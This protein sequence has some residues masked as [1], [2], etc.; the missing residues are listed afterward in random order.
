MKKA[1]IF[2]LFNFYFLKVSAQTFSADTASAIPISIKKTTD[3]SL[4]FLQ[5]GV[6]KELFLTADT[7]QKSKN[8]R[9]SD[10]MVSAMAA[11]SVNSSMTAK[12]PLVVYPS[13]NASAL[14][15]A[16]NDNIDLYTGKL[17]ASI[18]IYT[19]KGR[20]ISIPI[21]LSFNASGHKVDDIGSWVGM[22]WS[23]QAGGGISRVMHNLPDEFTGNVNP[24]YFPFPAYGYLYLK[25][26]P[27]YVDL[28]DFTNQTPAKKRQIIDYANWQ[29]QNGYCLDYGGQCPKAYDTH[30]DEFYFNFPGYS[31]KFVFDQDGNINITPKQNLIITKTIQNISGTNTLTNFQVITPDGYKYE[32]GGFD[33]NA[34]EE[35]QLTTLTKTNN[36]S[37]L[38][39]GICS[40]SP[41]YLYDRIPAT[42]LKIDQYGN[43][44]DDINNDYIS[45][46]FYF[47]SSWHLTSVTSP[48]GDQAI[49]EYADNGLLQYEQSRTVQSTFP[50]FQE[51]ECGTNGWFF[52]SPTFYEQ[53]FNGYF[54]PLN[55]TL[56][57]SENWIQLRSKR[58]TKVTSAQ[59]YISFEANTNR[60]DLPND[61]RLDYIRIY[62][63]ANQLLKKSFK[64]DYD[65]YSNTETNATFTWYCNNH[66]RYEG[67]ESTLP[68]ENTYRMFLKSV[69]ELDAIGQ[70]ALAYNFEYDNT[71]LPPRCSTSQ[72]YYGFANLNPT[73]HAFGSVG[74][75]S[76]AGQSM[77]VTTY[78]PLAWN[79]G[80]TQ[81]KGGIKGYN[82]AKMMAGSLKK[83]YYPTGGYKEFLYDVS[84]DGNSWNGLR[85]TSIKE[86]DPFST[87]TIT[88]N[89]TPTTYRASDAPSSKYRIPSYKN[90]DMVYISSDRTLPLVTTQGNVGGYESMEISKTGNGKVKYNFYTS[91]DFPDL[92]NPVFVEDIT[93]ASLANSIYGFP[94]P[95]KN[96]IDWQRGLVKSEEY[97]DNNGNKVRSVDYTYDFSPPLYNS[98]YSLSL[99]PGKI[100]Y[101]NYNG[102]IVNYLVRGIT[103]YYSK[104]FNLLSKTEKNYSGTNSFDQTE[105]YKYNVKNLLV[106]ETKTM[107]SDGEENVS[108]TKYNTDYVANSTNGLMPLISKSISNAVVEKYNYQQLTG[109]TN[110]R[111]KEGL[112]YSYFTD[113]PLVK[114]IHTLQLS[115][116]LTAFV[117]SKTDVNGNFSKDA[118]YV[119]EL[120]FDYDTYGNIRQQSQEGGIVEQYLYD[121]NSTLPIAKATNVDNA[122]D[123]AYTSFE[124][125]GKG[126]WNYSGTKISDLTSPTG[127][128][129]YSLSTGAITKTGLSSTKSYI[130]SYWYKPGTTVNVTG[131]TIGSEINGISR[132]DGWKYAERSITGSIGITISA[133]SGFID[134][135]KLFPA[136]AQMTTYSYLPLT[137]MTTVSESNG[138]TTTYEYDYSQRLKRTYNHNRDIQSEIGYHYIDRTPNWQDTGILR[139]VTDASGNNTGEQ[140]KEQK[141]VNSLSVTYNT[142]RWVSLGITG[143]CPLPCTGKDKKMINGICETGVKVT[144]ECVEKPSGG[145][146][147]FYHY[148][149]SDGST[150]QQYS[151]SRPS[152]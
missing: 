25:G 102:D 145:C 140:Q 96:I 133:A 66:S 40:G 73:L 92:G 124:A 120:N 103:T 137:G 68:T 56:S 94:F 93:G 7:L 125:D 48:T 39:S 21:S 106:N 42:S 81:V 17:S 82:L 89:Y 69:Q 142:T 118:N 74:Y 51:K 110:K 37:Y 119:P 16:N 115:K 35:S 27:E 116:P 46:Y 5:K 143:Q 4:V 53:R 63:G 105:S 80:L 122:N 26:S 131:G 31:G 90:D 78:S 28:A 43:Y 62:G 30:P 71:K 64:L 83:I 2:I 70:N 91:V 98:T 100:A 38:Y 9:Q 1:F 95:A 34:V 41:G 135:L 3:S 65:I 136:Y 18:P 36:Y 77:P 52:T 138:I 14:I 54:Y 147:C 19:L 15:A 8:L 76:N 97:Y 75:T 101:T 139:C 44:V 144:D 128:Y 32:F 132:T 130:L 107:R 113:K 129:Y 22:G 134:E 84:G 141:D 88:I 12:L 55:Q 20:D 109:E 58:L 45:Y 126:N 86:Y 11:T 149:W 114:Q 67:F 127:Y 117:E 123:I 49:F 111:Y 85:V 108:V 151:E 13:P 112:L 79:P 104:W 121:Y 47:P 61:K 60:T 152:C 10:G 87:K 57:I 6:L 72:D 150:S 29:Q 99:T 23:L 24:L 33:K 59:G 146:T 148:R 50:N